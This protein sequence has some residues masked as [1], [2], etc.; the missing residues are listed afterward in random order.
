MTGDTDSPKA[1]EPEPVD[2]TAHWDEKR[3][4]YEAQREAENKR[5]GELMQYRPPQRPMVQGRHRR[6]K[7]A[8]R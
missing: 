2:P 4:A 6:L 3:R 5:G 1:A 8:R 7:R